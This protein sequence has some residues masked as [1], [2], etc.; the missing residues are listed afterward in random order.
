MDNGMANIDI[1]PASDADRDQWRLLR[2]E[3]WPDCAAQKHALEI[4]QILDSEGVVFVADHDQAGIVGFAEISI[5]RDH[6]EGAVCS[7]VP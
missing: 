6:V 3:L 4:Q 2:Q 1:L 7:L 5:R